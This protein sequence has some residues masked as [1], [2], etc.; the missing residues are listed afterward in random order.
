MIAGEG[1]QVIERP[2]KDI[3]EFVLDP[4]QYK[5][6]DLKIG[7]VHSVTWNGGQAEIH[8]SGRFRGLPTPSVRQIITV[9]PYRRIDVRS[10]PGTVAHFMSRFH[11]T[12]TFEEL[13]NGVT[14]FFH[15]E[16]LVFRPPLKWFV[17]PLLRSWLENDTPQEVLRLKALLEATPHADRQGSTS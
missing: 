4:E 10:M 2:A 17:E 11:G 7:T 6:A 14:R 8:Y 12:F 9:Q 15:R 1:T 5:K 13:G 3:Y 16:E